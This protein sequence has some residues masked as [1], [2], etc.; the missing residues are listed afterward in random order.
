MSDNADVTG[1][2]E[3]GE[4]PRVMLALGA[5]TFSLD[6][7]AYAALARE[8]EW[9]WAEQSR[10]GKQDLLQ[11]TG[12]AGRTV[13]LEGE[14]LSAMPTGDPLAALDE[15]VALSDNTEPQLLVSSTGDM[16]GWWVIRRYSD[17]AISFLPG[18][19]VRHKTFTLTIQ[20]Y[21]DDIHNP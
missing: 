1:I 4:M 11:Y 17:N 10:A 15:L 6:T 14:A 20:H 18:G 9:R 21:A 2:G 3:Q 13:T 7:V 16:M 19:G 12:K 8:M 5:F